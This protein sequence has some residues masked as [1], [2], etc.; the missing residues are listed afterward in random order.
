MD[1]DLGLKKDVILPMQQLPPI[2]H[3]SREADRNLGR[4]VDYPNYRKFRRLLG[5]MVNVMERYNIT[6]ILSDG[7][8]LGSYLYHDMLPWDDDIDIR[9]AYG[10]YAKLK[11]VSL[12]IINLSCFKYCGFMTPANA[13]DL[14]TK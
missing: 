5:F 10:D 8:L 7:S 4:P 2:E 12:L 6:Y 13:C 11:K 14:S 3:L 9:V 1:N